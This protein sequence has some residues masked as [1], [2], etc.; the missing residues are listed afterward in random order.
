MKT[1]SRSYST[2]V[3]R[4]G[5][6]GAGG[7]AVL[8]VNYVLSLPLFFFNVSALLIDSHYLSLLW[9]T[10]PCASLFIIIITFFR[11]GYDSSCSSFVTLLWHLE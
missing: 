3:A 7:V 8:A 9:R 6:E 11:V 10:L 4:D 5:V 1:F 2:S